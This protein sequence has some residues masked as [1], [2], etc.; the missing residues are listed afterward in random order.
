MKH[1]LLATLLLMTC[2]LSAKTTS[3]QWFEEAK[4]GIFIHWGLYANIGYSEWNMDHF[5]IPPEEYSEMAKEFNPQKFDPK[6]WAKLFKKSGA[7]YAVVVSK[8]HDGFCLYDTKFTD[9]NIMNTP[10]GKDAVRL[11]KEACEAE[12]LKFGIYYSVMDWHHPDYLPRRYW[13]KRS[14][15]N[16]DLNRYKEFFKNQVRE[17][18]TEYNPAIIWF[19]G[20]W[21]GTFDDVETAEIT[22]MIY[23]LKPDILINNRL[24]N[25]AEGDFKTPEGFVPATGIRN[26]KGEKTVWETCS[27]MGDCWGYNPYQTNFFS[28][29]N[30]IRMLVEI[31]SKG[32]NLL[33]NVGP[34]ADGEIQPEFEDRLLKMGDW[35]KENGKAIY[36]CNENKFPVIPF[37]GTSV[38]SENKIYLHVFLKDKDNKIKLPVINGISSVKFLNGNNELNYKTE[39]GFTTVFIPDELPDLNS[40]VIEISLSDTR[41]N[42]EFNPTYKGDIILSASEAVFDP[43]YTEIEKIQYYDKVLLG[44]WNFKAN[45]KAVKW[46]FNLAESG[47]YLLEIYATGKIEEAGE[48]KTEITVND[49]VFTEI[50]PGLPKWTALNKALDKPGLSFETTLN[51]DKNIVKISMP[52]LINDKSLILEK[53]VL[54]KTG[55]MK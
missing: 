24:S 34:T 10:F 23:N 26:E 32:G 31:T 8:H 20:G 17:I 3:A 50:L 42:F 18:I 11:L 53:I 14:S 35:L 1:I 13:D 22:K 6:E 12:G 4:F 52:E 45:G 55:E 25:N 51:K 43:I 48:M 16:A 36:G 54:K 27:T 9:Y 47:K 5:R 41:Q 37:F 19:D 38:T 44:N 46:E 33:L 28:S 30:L 49:S 40:S 2:L 7:E 15:E 39:K 29:R 21:E